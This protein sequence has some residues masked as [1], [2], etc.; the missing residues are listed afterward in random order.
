MQAGDKVPD[1]TLP[2]QHGNP[3]SFTELIGKTSVVVFFYPKNFTPGCTREACDFRDHY[4]RFKELGAE[5][6]GISSDSEKS[7]SKFISKFDLPYTFLS[8]GKAKAR[9]AFGVKSNLF[10]L[11]PGRETFIFDENGRLLHKFNNMNE[12]KHVQ[13][14]LE[15]LRKK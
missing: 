10:G 1:I 4:S 15:V 11:L 9:K 12:G 2:D 5:V 13:E 14:A 8:D 6:I 7:H 3:F